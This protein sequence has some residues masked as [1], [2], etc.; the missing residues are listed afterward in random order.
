MALSKQ[1]RDYVASECIAAA[2]KIDATESPMEHLYYLSA[3]WAAPQRAFNI[4]FDPEM[5][6]LHVMLNWAYTQIAASLN[7]Q[8]SGGLPGNPGIEA[9]RRF[10]PLLIDLATRI[11]SGKTVDEVLE[12]I[13][14]VGYAAGGNGHYLEE[15]GRL[16]H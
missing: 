4:E 12:R 3:A 2:E 13:A 6:H 14:V 16:T 9:L 10:P 5:L 1:L 8:L 15:I 7:P 11:R